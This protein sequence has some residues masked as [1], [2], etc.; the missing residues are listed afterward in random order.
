M[1]V[2]PLAETEQALG[3]FYQTQR[4]TSEARACYQEFV[5]LWRESV[6][7][8]EYAARQR[9]AAEKLLSSIRQ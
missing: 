5:A 3:V 2:I 9:K 7:P 1:S 8:S 6:G 4:R